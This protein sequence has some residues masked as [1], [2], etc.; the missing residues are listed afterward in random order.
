MQRKETEKQK[1]KKNPKPQ[2][3]LL[4]FWIVVISSSVIFA[5]KPKLLILRH[6]L[7]ASEA[8]MGPWRNGL[9]LF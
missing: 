4:K 8:S 3:I 6:E 2:N 7:A 1:N 9:V 5:S